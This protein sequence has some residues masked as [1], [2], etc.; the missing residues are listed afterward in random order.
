[1]ADRSWAHDARAETGRVWLV[2]LVPGYLLFL[3]RGGDLSG[4]IQGPGTCRANEVAVDTPDR[5]RAGQRSC[6]Y[7]RSWSEPPAGATPYQYPEPL[8]PGQDRGLRAAGVTNGRSDGGAPEPFHEGACVPRAAS[9]QREQQNPSRRTEDAWTCT[10][11]S[12]GPKTTTTSPWRTGTGSCWP[13]AGSAT[14]RPG[15]RSCWPCSPGT[16][17]PPMTRSR[18]PSRHPAG[19]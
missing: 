6:R 11:G 3:T 9:G 5:F 18:W 1:M 10:A 7:V 19:C 14:T 2:W 4:E 8:S 15:W 17:T 16:A 12:T 13:A